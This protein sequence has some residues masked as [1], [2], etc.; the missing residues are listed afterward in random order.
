MNR[1]AWWANTF[2]FIL[3][4]W[5]C[6]SMCIRYV[7]VCAF[8][9]RPYYFDCYIFVIYFQIKNYNAFSFILSQNCFDYSGSLVI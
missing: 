9:P 8:I 7:S 3:F 4:Y 2:T 5:Y 1:G 6:M